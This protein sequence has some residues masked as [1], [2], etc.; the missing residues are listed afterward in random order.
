MK[1][2]FI[3]PNMTGGGAERVISV[4][5]NEFVSREI[6][7]KIL[8][9]AGNDNVYQLDKRIEVT[10]IGEL[11]T[12]DKIIIEVPNSVT[13]IIKLSEIGFYQR[14]RRKL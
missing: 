7:V 2:M 4:L 10:Q 11:S 14:M 9:T 8:M 5:A 6:D 3:I 13:K 12:G 1:I